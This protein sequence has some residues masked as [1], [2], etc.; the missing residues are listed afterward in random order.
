MKKINESFVTTLR[1]TFHPRIEYPKAKIPSA[2][3]DIPT[4]PS[5]ESKL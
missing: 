3:E 1:G 4:T 2:A 5:A